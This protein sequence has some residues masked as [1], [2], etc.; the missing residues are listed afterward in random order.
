MRDYFQLKLLLCLF[1]VLLVPHTVFCDAE[2]TEEEK[3]KAVYK[4]YEEYK[5]EFSSVGD[6][7]PQKAMS[8]MEEGRVLFVDVRKP[9]E[10]KVSMLPGAI[11]KKE[12]LKA[13]IK[14]KN[15]TVVAYCTIGY[16][17]GKF[18]EEMTNKG[19]LVYNL[20]GGVLVW[21]LEAGKVFDASGESKRVHVYGEKWNY[22]PE[23]YEA[24]VFGLL[25]RWF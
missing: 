17:S 4:M 3:K 20:K 10:I 23:G 24:V 19:I 13:P 22:L 9:A 5:K 12:Y 7:I 16:R 11:S 15:K 1:L 14:F 25:E 18:A 21:V 8:L 2:L 6:M